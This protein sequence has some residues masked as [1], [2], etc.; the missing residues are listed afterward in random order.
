MAISWDAGSGHGV[1]VVLT[2]TGGVR[3]SMELSLIESCLF[4]L[5]STKIERDDRTLCSVGAT[6]QSNSC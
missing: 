1:L 4:S 2:G 3:A 5:A 6:T